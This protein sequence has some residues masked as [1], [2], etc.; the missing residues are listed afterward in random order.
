MRVKTEPSEPPQP[1]QRSA[2]AESTTSSETHDAASI[3]RRW[4]RPNASCVG[5]R[6]GGALSPLAVDRRALPG[7]WGLGDSRSVAGVPDATRC[8][9]SANALCP[10]HVR[11]ATACSR[12]LLRCG[13]VKLP[14]RTLGSE[15]GRSQVSQRTSQAHRLPPVRPSG[16]C[17]VPWAAAQKH[18]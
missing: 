1:A 8:A 10:G 3:H 18:L 11:R 12:E 4:P 13:A 7:S 17:G 16:Q 6:P 14:R 2:E 15:G 5:L 9:R